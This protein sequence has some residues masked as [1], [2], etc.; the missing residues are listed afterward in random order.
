VS[1]SDKVISRGRYPV[2]RHTLPASLPPSLS[3]ADEDPH[4]ENGLDDREENGLEDD[5]ETGFNALT[6]AAS[7]SLPVDSQHTSRKNSPGV[8]HKRKRDETSSSSDGGADNGHVKAQKIN[9]NAGRPRAA[10]Y[11]DL[12]KD[13][14]LQAAMVYRCL[15]S[16]QDAFPDL[17]S[18]AEMVKTAWAHVNNENGFPSLTLTPSIAKIVSTHL[19]LGAILI[20][21]FRSRLVD[22]RPAVR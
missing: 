6:P 2:S 15:L 14:I 12:A 3:D 5:E 8:Q 13:L 19:L 9:S 4:E 20:G 10:D 7:P 21:F 17:A 18:E 22:R 16:T 1:D 11:E